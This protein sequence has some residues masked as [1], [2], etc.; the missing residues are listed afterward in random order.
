MKKQK[1]PKYRN[2]VSCVY[3]IRNTI[4]GKFL[5]GSTNNSKERWYSH[6]NHLNRGIHPNPHLQH[7][8]NKYGETVF[9]FEVWVE[10]APDKLFGIETAL[11]TQYCGL[12]QCYNINKSA[13]RLGIGRKWTDE[14]RIR[15]SERRKG[16][17]LTEEE[18]KNLLR[19]V[20]LN[21]EALRNV[22]SQNMRK[23]LQKVREMT[24]EE[25]QEYQRNR[26]KSISKSKLG[27]S[28]SKETRKKLSKSLTGKPWSEARRLAEQK[29]KENQH[30]LHK[31]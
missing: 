18:M 28:V 31:Q 17:K 11:L 29:R 4:N 19:P 23:A 26:G 16:R 24:P 20:K 15:E 8:W 30:G 13:D 6:R 10:A 3:L 22:K 25:Y 14:Q 7:A 1:Y 9:E 2:T 5:I 21:K 12:E 27:H